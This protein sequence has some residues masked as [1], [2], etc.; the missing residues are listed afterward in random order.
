MFLPLEKT[1]VKLFHV[2]RSECVET[3]KKS[4]AKW[5][6]NLQLT[7]SDKRFI[8]PNWLQ[9]HKLQT[10]HALTHKH[11]S[12]NRG[13]SLQIPKN[14]SLYIWFNQPSYNFFIS[15]YLNLK[16]PAPTIYNEAQKFLCIWNE[17]SNMYVSHIVT[18]S[19]P[20]NINNRPMQ[21][22]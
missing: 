17:K 5:N 6:P 1:H 7:V 12:S 9:S 20:P 2:S 11:E 15:H 16:Q 18:W 10:Y 4:M 14:T 3:I 22:I 8:A 19:I 13:Y 21:Q